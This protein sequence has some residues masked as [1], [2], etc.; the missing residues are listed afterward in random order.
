VPG[1][2]HTPV[3]K[4]AKILGVLLLLVL[5]GVIG[6]IAVI[7]FID[8]RSER[9]VVSIVAQLKPGTPFSFAM[10]RLGQSMYVITN[11]EGIDAGL[12]MFGARGESRIP[13]NS[14]LHAFVH[15]GPPY[16]FILVFTDRESEKI[17]HAEW[18]HM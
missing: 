5:V 8:Y 17:V 3:K 16:R 13:A 18:C 12:E 1:L 14:V 15:R 10:Q 7:G 11:D 6:F 4:F 2:L 9:E